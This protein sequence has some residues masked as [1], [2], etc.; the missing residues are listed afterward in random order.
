MKILIVKIFINENTF[1]ANSVTLLKMK[2]FTSQHEGTKEW[3]KS[4]ISFLIA[5]PSHSIE[6]VAH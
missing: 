1:K 2:Y 5:F 6:V 4:K 3:T